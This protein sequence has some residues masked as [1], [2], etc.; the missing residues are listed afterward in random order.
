MNNIE[1]EKKLADEGFTSKEIA[2][3]KN[4]IERDATTYQELLIDL[5]KRFIGG[6]IILAIVFLFY[7]SGFL[8]RD[9]TDYIAVAITLLVV[10]IATWYVAPL[11]LG[12]KAYFLIKK[13]RHL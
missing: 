13:N 6:V 8:V 4:L 12:A 10:F 11:K 3:L 5:R 7:G 2:I 9:D 1:M